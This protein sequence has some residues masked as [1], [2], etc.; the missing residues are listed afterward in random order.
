M[1]EIKNKVAQSALKTLSLE[2]YYPVGP[3][4][5]L[6]IAPWLYEGVMLREKDFR[7]NVNN[8]NWQ[9]YKNAYVAAFCSADAIIP[10]W[11]Y[12]LIGTH[13]A[14]VAKQTVYGSLEVLETVLMTQ[15]LNKVEVKAFADERVILKGCGDL[16]I[17]PHAYLH[18][19]S[20]LQPVV[21]SLMFGEACSTVPIYK[22]PKAK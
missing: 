11:A 19:V 15:A 6:N 22:K 7:K 3:R 2:D 17:P 20:R 16:P 12:M 5:E 14:G 21:K 13:L 8:H 1:E 10:Q 4:L 18:F 9:Q